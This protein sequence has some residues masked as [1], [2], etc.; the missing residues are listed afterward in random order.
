MD[1]GK[2]VVKIAGH[3]LNM[4]RLDNYRVAHHIQGF[5]KKEHKL[6]SVAHFQYNFQIGKFKQLLDCQF[7]DI[8]TKLYFL[9]TE[10]RSGYEKS[11]A[12]EQLFN[13][14]KAVDKP[15][16]VISERKK[17][18]EKYAGT[19]GD[20][21]YQE[22]GIQ[23]DITDTMALYDYIRDVIKGIGGVAKV[24]PDSI[25]WR[26]ENAIGESVIKKYKDIEDYDLIFGGWHA[27]IIG[28]QEPTIFHEDN[29]SLADA[30]VED[31]VIEIKKAIEVANKESI[32]LQAQLEQAQTKDEQANQ[33]LQNYMHSGVVDWKNEYS[34][35][36]AEKHTKLFEQ[37]ES[38]GK[39]VNLAL[40]QSNANADK[41]IHLHNLYIARLKFQIALRHHEFQPVVSTIQ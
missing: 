32:I 41:I 3:K 1:T 16:A 22:S 35:R 9:T 5:L 6:I 11:M 28:D 40:I 12:I 39:A 18:F 14:I 34:E 37:K 36:S 2:A 4:Q 33:E 38:T 30:F 8:P 24:S 27:S 7:S 26:V 20:A 21:F 31:C 15:L 17:I 19:F 10:G 25:L 23:L 29:P 13:E